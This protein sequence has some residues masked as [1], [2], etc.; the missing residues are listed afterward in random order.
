MLGRILKI[1]WVMMIIVATVQAKGSISFFMGDFL[2]VSHQNI[3]LR[4]SGNIEHKC[5][6]DRESNCDLFYCKLVPTH[7]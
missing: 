1:Q 5:V 2:F 4:C 7:K 3:I 6:K